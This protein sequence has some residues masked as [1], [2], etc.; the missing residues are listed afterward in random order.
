MNKRQR[1]KL[2]KHPIHALLRSAANYRGKGLTKSQVRS[3][4]KE[5]ELDEKG[6]LDAAEKIAK[7]SQA[8]GG[9]QARFLADEISLKVIEGLEADDSFLDEVPDEKL[10]KEDS[11]AG[12]E[13]AEKIDQRRRGFEPGGLGDKPLR[14]EDGSTL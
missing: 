5:H 3:F 12:K 14:F 1:R 11:D 8:D 9:F 6:L 4:A 13:I 10:S 2:Q 7:K